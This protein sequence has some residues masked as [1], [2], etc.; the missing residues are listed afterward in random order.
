MC[1]PGNLSEQPDLSAILTRRLD[2][3]S[4]I[5]NLDQKRLAHACYVRIVLSACW[6]VQ[7]KGSWHDDIQ[8]ATLISQLHF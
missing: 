5:L 2:Q 4:Q 7:A 1:N 3:F 8:Y 6:T